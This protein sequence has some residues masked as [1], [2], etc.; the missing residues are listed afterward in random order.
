MQVTDTRVAL[1]VLL[2]QHVAVGPV[3]IRCEGDPA[4]GGLSCDTVTVGVIGEQ[5][6]VIPSVS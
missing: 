4:I 6:V 3:G 5:V 2:F 1:F